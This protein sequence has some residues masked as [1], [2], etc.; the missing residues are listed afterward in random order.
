MTPSGSRDSD[1]TVVRDLD[2]EARFVSEAAERAER[3]HGLLV[4]AAFEIKTRRRLALGERRY[5]NSFLRRPAH[6]RITELL[7]EAWD[8]TAYA[9]LEA[10]IRLAGSHVDSD[11]PRLLEIAAHAAAIHAHARH[12]DPVDDDHEPLALGGDVHRDWT[13]LTGRRAA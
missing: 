3:R 10:Q 11:A 8:A 9:V 6:D 12:L 2:F 1:L 13:R 4:G 7:E 5:G